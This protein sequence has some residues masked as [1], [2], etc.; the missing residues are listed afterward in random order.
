MGAYM[1]KIIMYGCVILG[2]ISVSGC[3]LIEKDST[4][5]PV[6]TERYYKPLNTIQQNFYDVQTMYD[7]RRYNETIELGET[8][9]KNYKRDI[10]AP[11][12]KYYMGASHQ[13][14]G[15]SAEAEK[16][17]KNILT[18]NPEDEWGKL[19]TVGMQEIKAVSLQTVE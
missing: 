15:N 2:I 6:T 7:T 3:M 9:L 17:Y 14:L 18:T 1:Q 16:L 5:A 12:V 10:L 19:A 11:A 4:V 8:F 13:A